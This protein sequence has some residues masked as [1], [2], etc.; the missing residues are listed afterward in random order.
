MEEQTVG[1]IYSK[2]QGELLSIYDEQESH[3]INTMIFGHVMD[4][5]R[6][7]IHL[8]QNQFINET[9]QSEVLFIL[10]ELKK[11]IPVQYVFGY[12]WFWEMKL[13]VNQ[14]VLIPR[15][16]TEELVDWIIRD[17]DSA[18]PQRIVDICTGS[19]C[20]ALALKKKFPNAIVTAVDNSTA[21]LNVARNNAVIQK[22]DIDFLQEDA[23]RLKSDLSPDIIVSNP[24][25]VLLS[26]SVEMTKQVMEYEPR[27]ALFVPDEDPLV[28]YRRIGE[29]AYT[30]MEFNKNIYFEINEVMGER[31]S[32]LLSQ[33]GFS[34][35]IIRN[36]MQGKNRMVRAK[37]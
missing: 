35:V 19:G 18:S 28:F 24:P 17:Y 29:W 21:A 16:E 2:I 14:S 36:D 26:Q 12:A 5:S 9:Q 10:H 4:L 15:R 11:G 7:D 25:Y 20:I 31:V 37:K 22:L 1:S 13:V 3:K 30:N 32:E 34:E 27:E 8:K 23:L 6:L 33:L